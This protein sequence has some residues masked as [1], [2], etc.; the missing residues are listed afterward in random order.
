MRTGEIVVRDLRKSTMEGRSKW[1]EVADIAIGNL[2]KYEIWQDSLN[3]TLDT[4]YEIRI[5]IKSI[6]DAINQI[7]SEKILDKLEGK[8]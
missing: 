7:I 5:N 2:A 3:L 4:G 1:D 8:K 6:A